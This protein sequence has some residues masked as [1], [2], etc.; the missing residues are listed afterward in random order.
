MNLSSSSPDGKE[1][2]ASNGGN[3][4]TLSYELGLPRTT[5][6]LDQLW[7][8][9]QCEHVTFCFFT[10]AVAQSASSMVLPVSV[11]RD[12]DGQRTSML[13]MLPRAFDFGFRG[14]S[15]KNRLSIR[16]D[17]RCVPYLCRTGTFV[18]LLDLRRLSE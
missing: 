17:T 5:S 3:L 9:P 8:L 11:S 14:G 13:F 18:T 10:L 4:E 15:N 2:A 12:V 16:V 1:C 6:S 7:T